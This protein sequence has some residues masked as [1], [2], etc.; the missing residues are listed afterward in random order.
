[1]SAPA[2]PFSAA[3]GLDSAPRAPISASQGLDS[4]P[5]API[6]ASPEPFSVSRDPVRAP[7][8][9]ASTFSTCEREAQDGV[10]I[11]T[12]AGSPS[13]SLDSARRASGRVTSG[14]G[15]QS[16]PS[17]WLARRPRRAGAAPTHSR[18]QLTRRMYGAHAAEGSRYRATRPGVSGLAKRGPRHD[19]AG[20]ASGPDR[21]GG[22]SGHEG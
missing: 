14:P 2:G 21:H 12:G 5:R 18:P 9:L 3:Q 11:D 15:S 19:C 7:H 13:A 22:D 6:W 4:V 10:S 16:K 8:G 17:M 20:T 1:M